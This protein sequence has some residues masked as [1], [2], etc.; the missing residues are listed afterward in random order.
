MYWVLPLFTLLS[1]IPIFFNFLGHVGG[2]VVA[3]LLILV[4]WGVVWMRLYMG[5]LAR[6]ELAILTIA[7]MAFFTYM[8]AVP[9]AMD[10]LQGAMWS[11]LYFFSW[12]AAAIVGS[13]SFKP[14]ADE[15]PAKGE[16]DVTRIIL[17]SICIIFC[18]ITWAQTSFTLFLP[19]QN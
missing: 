5:Q 8:R 4:S 7:P 19:S 9:S 3:A 13:M 18:L 15:R 14:T 17:S 6:P 10:A 16:R 2:L 11:N 1:S 12:V